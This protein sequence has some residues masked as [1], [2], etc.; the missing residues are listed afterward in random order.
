MR[1]CVV[2]GVS[3]RKK[4]EERELR[5]YMPPNPGMNGSRPELPQ[6]INATVYIWWQL[7]QTM[8]EGTVIELDKKNFPG[9]YKIRYDDGDERWEQLKIIDW[10]N[11]EPDETVVQGLKDQAQGAT[12]LMVLAHPDVLKGATKLY[13]LQWSDKGKTWSPYVETSTEA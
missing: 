1:D 5:E 9:W 8:H 6:E 13:Y 12:G 2:F 4:R 10:Y 7:P 3:K 11:E